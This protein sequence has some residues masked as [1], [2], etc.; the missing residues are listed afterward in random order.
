M[1]GLIVLLYEYYKDIEFIKYYNKKNKYD[2]SYLH[3]KKYDDE[4]DSLV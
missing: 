2:K 3:Y 4:L 1:V